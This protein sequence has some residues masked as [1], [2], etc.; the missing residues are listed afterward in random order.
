MVLFVSCNWF[1]QG[2]ISVGGEHWA[3]NGSCGKLWFHYDFFLS[4]SIMNFMELCGIMEKISLKSSGK[5]VLFFF[6]RT[7]FEIKI[8][9][10]IKFYPKLV[11]DFNMIHF[12]GPRTW[13]MSQ[14]I[15]FL[16][17]SSSRE[18][19]VNFKLFTALDL[20]LEDAQRASI[21]CEFHLT[22][23]LAA[24]V[25]ISFPPKSFCDV[26]IF[27]FIT[28]LSHNFRCRRE[29]FKELRQT[30]RGKRR[31]RKEARTCE[32]HVSRCRKQNT[33]KS[34]GDLV[35]IAKNL[36]QVFQLKI[37]VSD[38]MTK[39]KSENRVV[40]SRSNFLIDCS[41][42]IKRE[43]PTRASTRKFLPLFHFTWPKDLNSRFSEF[44]FCFVRL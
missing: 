9:K 30:R 43:C 5:N 26:I 16:T 1:F 44:H 4:C 15:M 32:Y 14:Q 37:S 17:N 31:K 8:S 40:D 7:N 24:E 27:I 35:K 10:M 38:A 41:F 36:P 42:E 13:Q 29:K 2:W 23:H 34:G 25:S 11:F 12:T 20:S 18:I 3:T 19:I 21:K 6:R 39:W 22:L 28:H 33:Q